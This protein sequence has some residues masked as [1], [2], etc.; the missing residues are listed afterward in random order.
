MLRSNTPTRLLLEKYG[1]MIRALEAE[2]ASATREF[3][4]RTLDAHARLKE[5]EAAE[6]AAGAAEAR[7]QAQLDTAART[8]K[9]LHQMRAL[10]EQTG[11]RLHLGDDGSISIL[12]PTPLELTGGSPE[13]PDPEV[14][15][16]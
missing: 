4:K 7:R 5:A 3:K 6:A 12:D 10:Q 2:R 16:S 8:L 15:D 9:I 1:A 11:L 14:R 13:S